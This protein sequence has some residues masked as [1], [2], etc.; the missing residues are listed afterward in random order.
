MN[1]SKFKLNIVSSKLRNL[2]NL[3][4]IL[5]TYEHLGDRDSQVSNT[6]QPAWSTYTFMGLPVLH[7]ETLSQT[8]N[9]V[10]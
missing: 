1:Q 5:K 6:L 3:K 4:K 9:K 2:G 10:K 8:N 7:R